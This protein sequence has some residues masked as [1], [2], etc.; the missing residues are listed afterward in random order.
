[1]KQNQA[2]MI[3]R[4]LEEYGS[5]TQAEAVREFGCYRLSARIFDLREQGH[6]I[7]KTICTEKN[8]FG[9]PVTFARYWIGGEKD[10]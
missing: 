6:D 4:Y 7:R 5:I 10:A 9:A 1:M 2:D 8:R 3:L